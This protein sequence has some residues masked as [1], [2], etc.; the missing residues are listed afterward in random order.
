[1][2]DAVAQAVILNVLL[3][4]KRNRE[5]ALLSCFLLHGAITDIW[6]V[7]SVSDRPTIGQ[8]ITVYSAGLI[9]DLVLA[10]ATVLFLGAAA[11][12]MLKK[13]RRMN[14]KYGIQGEQI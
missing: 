8:F 12:P 2:L 7:L 9:P 1:M 4:Y 13:L 3:D 5:N 14:V 10:A 6:T 11:R